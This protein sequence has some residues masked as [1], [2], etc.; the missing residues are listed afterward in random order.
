MSNKI[1]YRDEID[2]D[3]DVDEDSEEE[4]IVRVHESRKQRAGRLARE[5]AERVKTQPKFRTMCCRY[6]LFVLVVGLGL[7]MITQL[8]ST[9]GEYVTDAIFP[10]RISSAA[11]ICSNGTLRNDYMVKFERFEASDNKTGEGWIF[12]NATR[13]KDS[14]R[15]AW[16]DGEMRKTE[17]H[18][19]HL[20]V[21][22]KN[23]LECVN[24]IVW[25]V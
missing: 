21:W 18:E 10:P 22:T 23:R 4:D 17:W 25:S 7:G 24:F 9:Y 12:A 11:E 3:A 15:M 8:Y 1:K 5:T 14:I 6:F 2:V 16:M 20:K 13:P 19:P